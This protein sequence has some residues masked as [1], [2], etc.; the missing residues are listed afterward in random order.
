[1]RSISDIVY[2]AIERYPNISLLSDSSIARAIKSAE[3]EIYTFVSKET[4][5][6]FVGV[7]TETSQL[8]AMPANYR[9]DN[10]IRVVFY[11]GIATPGIGY[12]PVPIESDLT[13]F[14]YQEDNTKILLSKSPQYHTTVTVVYKA[15]PVL[16]S[17]DSSDW[18]TIYPVVD[19]EYTDVLTYK[20]IKNLS[21]FG[22]IPDIAISNNYE[23]EYQSKL[24]KIK[25]D[26]YRRLR[27]NKKD[28]IDYKDYW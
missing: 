4:K 7:V 20:I 12:L 14:K 9:S 6:D 23:K 17:N 8:L 13:Q 10:L 28:R 11:Q 1:M 3:D 26:Y 21:M 15:V 22:D 2:E 18:D 27:K 19:D 16:I 5:Y 24:S 25:S